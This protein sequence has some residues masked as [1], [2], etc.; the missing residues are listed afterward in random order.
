M[1]LTQTA[2]SSAATIGTATIP[3]LGFW[4]VVV[5]VIMA[6]VLS[7]GLW[8]YLGPL[9][10][11]SRAFRHAAALIRK[12]RGQR[13]PFPRR[14]RHLNDLWT[15]FLKDREGTTVAVDGAEISTVDPEDTFSEHAVLRGYNRNM[16]LGFAG[17]FTGL[18]ILGTFLGLVEG[19]S[20]I[21]GTEQDQVMS[22]ILG[23]LGGMS[24]AF[25]TS[26]FGITLSLFWLFFDRALYY[27]IQ[28]EVIDFLGAVRIAYPVESA[29][30]LLHRLL[31]VEQEESAAI[32][33]T[34]RILEGHGEVFRGSHSLLEE[35]KAILQ[36]LGTDLAVAFQN[37]LDQSV[38]EKL[39]PA[40]EKVVTSIETLSTQ[41]GDRQVDMMEALVDNFSQGLTRQLDGQFQGLAE[42]LERTAEWQDRVHADLDDLLARVREATE[43]QRE[44][45]ERS[46]EMSTLFQEGVTRLSAAHVQL[47]GSADRVEEASG[48]ISEELEAAT[49]RVTDLLESTS[50]T[51]TRD[52]E[53]ASA[54]IA[55]M[56]DALTSSIER[57]DLQARALESRIEQLDAQQD[58]YREANEQIRTYLAAH[59][60]R[61]DEQVGTLTQFWGDFRSD[62]ASVGDQLQASVAE[63]SVFTADKL[64]EIFARFDSEMATVVQHLS[65]T[66]AE[67]REVNEDLP[68]NIERLRTTLTSAVTSLTDAGKSI[69][70]LVGPLQKVEDL[71]VAIRELRPLG[72]TIR[73]AGSQVESTDSSIVRLGEQIKLVDGR[74][75][76]A[77]AVANR[78]DDR[79]DPPAVAVPVRQ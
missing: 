60:D 43:G 68:G 17:V 46:T 61:L 18:G 77:I 15:Q 45:I 78:K 32:H 21:D 14:P 20:T 16:A 62:L 19:L 57:V 65:G 25:Y 66:L 42:A 47:A 36:T 76:M 11:T 75:A 72:E 24:T 5:V 63:F 37:A 41:L 35:Q 38:T 79:G 6:M 23:L 55:G 51:L 53:R 59:V 3:E 12:D 13:T 48:R 22:S 28:R 1:N 52:L 71:S 26:I 27:Q 44:V 58:T 2:Q 4:G 33:K 31:A 10:S 69:D 49:G 73:T 8:R 34:N 40:L 7:F 67:I 39:V 54:T 64:K 30:R 70:R 50:G 74:L 56:A 9:W 29:D